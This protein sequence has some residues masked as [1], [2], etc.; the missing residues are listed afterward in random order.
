M[1]DAPSFWTLGWG[2]TVELGFS[3]GRYL[4]RESALLLY[5]EFFGKDGEPIMERLPIVKPH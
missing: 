5:P 2:L 4:P 3:D 1:K